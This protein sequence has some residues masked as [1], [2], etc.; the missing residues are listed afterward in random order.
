WA[1]LRGCHA[2]PTPGRG[3]GWA[4]GAPPGTPRVAGPPVF[5]A[6]R[7]PLAAPPAPGA[8]P[9]RAARSVPQPTE[10]GQRTAFGRSAQ[11]AK[12]IEARIVSAA[13]R[14][15]MT[16]RRRT[17]DP[18]LETAG[19]VNQDEKRSA[20]SRIDLLGDAIYVP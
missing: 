12:T 15:P 1:L 10:R 14:S 7:V 9:G 8:Y 4:G 6:P 17:S 3:A 2:L 16:A 5:A 20:V 13:S 19:V 18:K 11:E